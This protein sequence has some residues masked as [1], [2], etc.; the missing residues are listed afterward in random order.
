MWSRKRT[1]ANDVRQPGPRPGGPWQSLL[2]D[3][4]LDVDYYAAQA[5]RSF[6]SPEDAARHLHGTGMALGLSP[7]PLIDV[8]LLPVP[9]RRGWHG[10]QLRRALDHL[11]S[12]EGLARPWSALFD[13]AQVVSSGTSSPDR[14][15]AWPQVRA[16]LAGLRAEQELPTADARQQVTW[17]AARA[18]LIAHAQDLA[19]QRRLDEPRTTDSWDVAAESAWLAAVEREPLPDDAPPLV[20][21]VMPVWNRAHRVREAVASVQAQDL[22]A[23]ELVVVDDGSTDDT[24]AVLRELAADDARIVVVEAP[25]GGV[26]QAR[27]AGLD[28]A[29]G[30]YVAFLD[31]DNTWRPLYLSTMVRAMAAKGLS[32]AYAGVSMQSPAGLQ[33]RAYDGDREHLLVHNHIDLNVLM[34]SSDVARQVGGFDTELRRWVDHD[35]VLRVAEVEVP[36][37]LPFL[38]CDYDDRDDH[39]DPDRITLREPDNWQFAVLGKAWVDWDEAARGLADRVTGRTSVVIAAKVD[40]SKTIAAAWSAVLDA[41]GD[42]VEVVV[43]DD[44]LPAAPSLALQAGLLGVPGVRIERLPRRLHS[45]TAHNVGVVRS[46]GDTVMLLAH[47]CVLRPGWRG[48]LLDRLSDDGV[49]GVQS[50]VLGPDDTISSA[51]FLFPV[52]DALPVAAAQ[53]HP[54]ED[55]AALG[56]V[57]LPAVSAAAL[58]L[59][60]RDYVDLG[61]LDPRYVALLDDVDLCL[62]ARDRGIGSFVLEPRSVASQSEPDPNRGPWRW[63][64]PNRRLFLERWRGRL[65]VAGTAVL[66]ALGL[67]M[68]G[69]GLDG[70]ACPAPVPVLVRRRTAEGRGGP[71]RWSLNSPVPAGPEGDAAELSGV[72]ERLAERLRAHGHAAAVVRLEAHHGSAGRDADVA[73]A[74]RLDDRVDPEPGRVNVLWV[75]GAAGLPARETGGFDVVAAPTPERAGELAEMLGVRVHV[76]PPDPGEAELSSLLEAVDDLGGS[77]ISR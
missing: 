54:R 49:V 20:S 56:S 60:A 14:P 5:G 71:L 42:D 37:L 21:V 19:A 69:I 44:G 72:C 34:L 52:A 41:D 62:R 23:W 77:A 6:G 73:V 17:G 7:H 10:G 30:R 36:R 68:V 32:A 12:D 15:G 2:D 50:L 74:V 38:G 1:Q 51:G 46:T 35:Y 39:P 18:A 45:A 16:W 65:P 9:I 63:V 29:R 24:V 66:D 22:D 26:S 4:L 13:P 70:A 40:V 76:L 25:H 57:T 8:A 55:A 67:D 64:T 28:S 47:D 31:S 61:G 11:R 75:L 59:D 27:N 3:G 43:V 33:Y 58:M 53:G 48:P